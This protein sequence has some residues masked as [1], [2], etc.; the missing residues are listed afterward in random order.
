[1]INQGTV[2]G[3]VYMIAFLLIGIIAMSLVISTTSDLS[4]TGDTT[5]NYTLVDYFTCPTDDTNGTNPNG[6][7][8]D[9]VPYST[10]YTY[11]EET[12]GG[13]DDIN[14]SEGYT[15]NGTFWALG[16]DSGAE[17][18]FMFL[19]HN[20]DEFCSDYGIE[21]IAWDFKID[22]ATHTGIDYTLYDCSSGI[23]VWLSV[24]DTNVTLYTTGP[25]KLWNTSIDNDTWYRFELL[26]DWSGAGAPTYNSTLYGLDLPGVFSVVLAT[27]ETT[28]ETGKLWMLVVDP[29]R[30]GY[31]GDI[32]TD[33]L[34]IE[35]TVTT[36]GGESHMIDIMTQFY[37]ACGVIMVVII[38]SILLYLFHAWNKR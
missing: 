29:T 33:D 3:I 2:K 32:F 27:N 28:I 4:E 13:V 34:E 31:W 18:S 7:D 20:G 8:T 25:T 21:R 15:V 5:T 6:N 23:I 37:I 35:Y 16:N 38:I 26:I 10:F 9:G 24:L 12:W 17:S 1:M 11:D 19:D 30:A 22:N 14:D 36:P